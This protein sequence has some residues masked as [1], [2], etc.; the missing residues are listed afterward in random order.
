MK[1]V[2]GART[3]LMERTTA[4]SEKAGAQ[5]IGARVK[6]ARGK[7]V[8]REG[9]QAHKENGARGYRRKRTVREKMARK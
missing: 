9:E 5:G 1:V 4:L 3:P 7:E 2:L 8:V 6:T